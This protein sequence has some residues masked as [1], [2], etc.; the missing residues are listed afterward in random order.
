MKV[1]ATVKLE[2]LDNGQL[3]VHGPLENKVLCYGMAEMF[4]ESVAKYH[5]GELAA[6]PAIVAAPAGALNRLPAMNGN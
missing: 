4:K 2:L 3:Q 1:V 6:K 5:A